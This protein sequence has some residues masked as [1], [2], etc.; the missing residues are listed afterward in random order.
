MAGSRQKKPGACQ[1]MTAEGET[2]IKSG[3]GGE[4]RK[5]AIRQNYTRGCQPDRYFR[6]HKAE[7]I[8]SPTIWRVCGLKRIVWPVR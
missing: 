4:V 6:A 8:L 1:G 3:C 5:K 2:R 7:A